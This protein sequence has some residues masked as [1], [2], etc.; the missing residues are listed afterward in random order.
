MYLWKWY[1]TL[2]LVIEYVFRFPFF[3]KGISNVA[4]NASVPCFCRFTWTGSGFNFTWLQASNKLR[5][6]LLTCLLIRTR[7]VIKIKDV[8]R[9]CSGTC[10][11]WLRYESSWLCVRARNS[12]N[13]TQI[14]NWK[15]WLGESKR[16]WQKSSN[17]SK[18]TR[19]VKKGKYSLIYNQL[20]YSLMK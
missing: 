18:K 17:V 15:C 12:R 13:E 7:Y 14:I 20:F 8:P 4:L 9:N 2:T 11:R 16:W 19:R 3:S 1:T 6:I 5:N 10:K